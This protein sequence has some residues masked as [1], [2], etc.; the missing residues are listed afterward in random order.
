MEGEHPLARQ[1]DDL[2]PALALD[3][4]DGVRRDL[5]HEVDSAALEREHAGLSE[6]HLDELDAGELL[7]GL[8]V[9]GRVLRERQLPGRVALELV[10][11]GADRLR[12]Q[13]CRVRR[14][15]RELVSAPQFPLDQRLSRRR[16][17]MDPHGVVV[18]DLHRLDGFDVGRQVGPGR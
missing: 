7:R 16:L 4:G 14:R 5:P 1:R 3:R 13:V 6:P 9:E 2:Q 15:H 18:D 8:V 10:G 17:Q 11:A 12:L